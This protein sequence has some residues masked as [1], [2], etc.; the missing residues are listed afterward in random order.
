MTMQH[1]AVERPTLAE[2]TNQALQDIMSGLSEDVQAAV[3]GS[4][5]RLLDSDVAK[6]AVGVGNEVPDFTLPDVRGGDLRLSEALKQGPVVLSFSRGGW[7]PFCNLE[8][9][10][11]QQRLPEMKALGATLIGVSPR[12]RTT[13]CL[14]WRSIS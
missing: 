8:F 14:R 10:A 13:R 2:Q 6:D 5:E 7:C 1:A 4:F 3:A 9:N 12:R 11:L